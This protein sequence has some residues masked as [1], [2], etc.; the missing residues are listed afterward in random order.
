MASVGDSTSNNNQSQGGTGSGTGGNSTSNGG[1]SSS[2]GG[3]NHG[4]VG[5]TNTTITTFGGTDMQKSG[6]NS[7]DRIAAYRF[8]YGG[9]G[10]VRGIPWPNVAIPNYDPYNYINGA[11]QMPGY[12]YFDALNSLANFSNGMAPI[13]GYYGAQYVSSFIFCFY[14]LLCCVVFILVS[15]S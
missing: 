13:G 8:D 14:L 2:N 4:A 15:F 1:S 6:S 11:A 12:G 5:G 7:F 10:R 9:H 3:S